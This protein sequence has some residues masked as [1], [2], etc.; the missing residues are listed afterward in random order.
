MKTLAVKAAHWRGV[1]LLSPT[2][3]RVDALCDQ[4]REGLLAEEASLEEML[5]ELRQRR[6]AD[7]QIIEAQSVE[8]EGNAVPRLITANPI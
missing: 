4:L 7:D 1:F 8:T 6:Q 3:S 2:K 5:A